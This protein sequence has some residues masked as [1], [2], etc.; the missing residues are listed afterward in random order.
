MGLSKFDNTHLGYYRNIRWFLILREF[1]FLIPTILITIYIK[2][3]F[4]KLS[5]IHFNE[6]TLIPTIYIFKK[7][8]QIPFVLH[9]RILFKKNNYFGEQIIKFISKNISK[10]IVIDSDVK[11]SF[12]M[13][14][15]TEV[16]RNIF[17]KKIYP[18][19]KKNDGYLNLGY[20]GSFLKYKGLEDLINVIKILNKKN[21]K[22]RLYLAGNFVKKNFILESLNLSNNV[23]KKILINKNIIILGHLDN[24]KKFYQKIDILCFPSYLNALGRQVIEAGMYSIPSIVCI[25]KNTDSFINYKTG[26]SFKYPGSLK[27]LEKKIIFFNNNRNEIKKMGNEAKKLMKKNHDINS[28]K[29]RLEK[30][31]QSLIKI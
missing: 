16:V 24:L 25:K 30:I 22:V 15:S 20:L 17:V 1:F 29:L 11:N 5:I 8:F 14:L 9:C 21:Y 13:S 26:L 3:K 19:S 27:V 31:Y 12:P 2:L 28:N 18:I 23:S 7:F 4:K 6:I 10:I